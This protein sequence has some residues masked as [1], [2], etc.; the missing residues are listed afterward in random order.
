MAAGDPQPGVVPLAAVAAGSEPAR[1][2]VVPEATASKGDDTVAPARG[3]LRV[4]SIDLL[5]G[6]VMV[7]MALDH[8]RDYFH[9][10]EVSPT[11]LSQASA[12][13]FLTRLVTHLCAPTFV[14]LAGTAAF[15]S[16]R[17]GGAS[18]RSQSRHLLVRGLWLI[19]L[20]LTLVRWGW[21][22]NVNYEFSGLQVIWALGW[23]MVAL[24]GLIW[25]RWPAMLAVGGGMVL[26]HNLTDPWKQSSSPFPEWLW[27]ILHHRG[28]IELGPFKFYVLYP[29]IPWIGVMALG[30]LFG[31]L[32]DAPADVRRKRCLWLGGACLAAFAFLRP[33]NIYGEPE[34]WQAPAGRPALF[35][36]FAFVNTTKYPPSLL[37]L[38]MTLGS[39]FL[40][41]AAFEGW[42]SRD[43]RAAPAA[44]GPSQ[45]VRREAPSERLR[46][47][48]LLFGRVPLFFYLL[49]LPLIHGLALLNARVRVGP[50][51]PGANPWEW[52][53]RAAYDLPGVHIAW[54][55]IILIL[56]PLCARYDA[57]KRARPGGW[58]RY[59]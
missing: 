35:A 4:E 20:E 56:Y 17:N 12:A 1:A 26:L 47:A 30:Y 23:S 9:R 22:F 54:M 58:T 27:T 10:G 38:L 46:R 57:Y 8:T 15:L 13:L 16:A 43:G 42:R 14:F 41:L 25:L 45:G 3:K 33:W 31:A 24:A 29:L 18:R 39:M 34:P 44:G 48:L 21:Q 53:T 5:R 28:M 50:P 19:L 6:L 11:D 52:G 55:A 7:I 49:H 32:V 40:L 2:A 37:F 51:P 59:L 36:A